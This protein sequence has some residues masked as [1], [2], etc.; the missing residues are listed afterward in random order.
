MKQWRR[1]LSRAGVAESFRTIHKTLSFIND[2]L[3][4]LCNALAV[5]FLFRLPN[6]RFREPDPA[7]KRALSEAK[8]FSDVEEMNSSR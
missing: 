8:V 2:L 7:I 1:A 4:Q 3:C 5:Y 6:G